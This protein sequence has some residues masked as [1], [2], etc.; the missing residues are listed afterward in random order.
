MEQDKNQFVSSNSLKLITTGV[1]SK[2]KLGSEGDN[3]TFL[4]EEEN[5]SK[6]D[7][8]VQKM[9]IAKMSSKSMTNQ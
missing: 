5:N 8:G 4:N 1:S 2:L 3:V 9:E 6:E 7:K